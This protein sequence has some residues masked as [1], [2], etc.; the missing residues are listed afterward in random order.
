[1]ASA[2]D[3][4]GDVRTLASRRAAASKHVPHPGAARMAFIAG[5]AATRFVASLV[6]ELV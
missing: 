5:S 6:P 3:V 4:S 2:I 1:M